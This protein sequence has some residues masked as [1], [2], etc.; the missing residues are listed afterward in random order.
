M[1]KKER[2]EL[3]YWGL[4][5]M[6]ARSDARRASEAMT[7]AELKRRLSGLGV[8]RRC[9]PPTDWPDSLPHSMRVDNGFE[10]TSKRFKERFVQ[11]LASGEAESF[12]PKSKCVESAGNA[13][14]KPGRIFIHLRVLYRMNYLGPK[15]SR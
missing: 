12:H 13:E 3:F 11:M 5:A 4:G 8:V 7:V 10:L 9:T 6:K 14:S 1:D 2:R 15:D